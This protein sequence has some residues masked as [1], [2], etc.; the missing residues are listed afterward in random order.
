LA[1]WT[2]VLALVVATALTLLVAQVLPA[3]APTLQLSVTAASVARTGL[4][5]LAAG[6]LAALLPLRRLATVAA[7]FQEAR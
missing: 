4:A 7:A 1:L 3:V 6:M 2:V 5:A